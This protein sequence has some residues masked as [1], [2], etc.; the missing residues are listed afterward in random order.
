MPAERLPCH[1]FA[2]RQPLYGLSAAGYRLE[3]GFNGRGEPQNNWGA[4]ERAGK[5]RLPPPKG[6][7]KTQPGIWQDP[8]RVLD[9]AS[10]AGA[11][12]LALSVEWARIEPRPGE[13]D[14]S[15]LEG[16]A[17]IFAAVSSRGIAPIAVLHDVAHPVWLG[18]EFWLTPGAPDRFAAHVA[19]VVSSLGASCRHWVTLRQANLVALAGWVDRRYPPRRVAALAD[20]WAVVDNFL[21]AHLLA[22]RTIHDHQPGACVL[23]GLR[24]SPCFDWQRLMVDLLC[25]PA[26]GVERGRLDSWVAHRRARHD[27]RNP[28]TDLADLAWRRVA[29]ATSPFG[30]GRLARPSPA[31]ALDVAY[32]GAQRADARSGLPARGSATLSPYPLDALLVGW[33]PPHVTLQGRARARSGEPLPVTIRPE[34]LALTGWCEEQA[35]ATPGLRIWVED[36]F[37]TCPGALRPDGWSRGAYLRAQ[38]AAFRR[39]G[40]LGAPIG[41]YLYFAPMDGGDPT[42]PD[43]DFGLGADAP[44]FRRLVTGATHRPPAGTGLGGAP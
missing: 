18:D 44:A 15:A 23:L 41:G 39:A 12:A 16:Y 19:R 27:A 29:A 35:C 13:L 24:A 42:W 20:A 14:E 17:A 9:L 34:P 21:T 1:A 30:S 3:G 25:A 37:A 31:R 36:G 5:L 26:L 10:T 43:A 6:G 7:L 11:E 40:A 32:L 22:Y 33:R 8:A 2:V 28:P 4:W 38:A